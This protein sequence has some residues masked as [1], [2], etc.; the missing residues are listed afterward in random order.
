MLVVTTSFGDQ[1]LGC[2]LVGLFTCF[3]S[4]FS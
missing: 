1:G 4:V 2:F 3:K